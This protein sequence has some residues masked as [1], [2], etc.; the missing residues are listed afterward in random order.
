MSLEPLNVSTSI[1]ERF[2]RYLSTAFKVAPE[3]HGLNQEFKRLVREPGRLFR[4]PYLQGLPP[5][6]RQESLQELIDLG[7]LPESIKA[8]PFLGSPNQQLYAHQAESIKRVQ[9]GHN[10]VVTSGTGSGKTL[11]FMIP[12]IAEI[13][14]NPAPGIHTMLLYPMNALVQDQLKVLRT[15]LKGHPEVRFGRYVNVNVTP[16]SET[17]ARDLHPDSLPN[18][19]VSR[20]VFRKKPPHI[21]ITNFAMLEHLLMRASDS[22][23]FQG[24]WRFIAMDETHTYTGARGSEVALL[25]R[26]LMARVKTQDEPP[27]QFI[28]TS[29]TIGA[30][31]TKTVEEVAKFAQKLF[32]AP[33]GVE[34]IIRAEQISMPLGD[35]LDIDP[36]I[37]THAELED[38]LDHLNWSE[39][40]VPELIAAGFP[41]E[42]VDAGQKIAEKDFA[43]ALCHI[44]KHDRR[45]EALREAVAL[46]PDLPAGAH[47]VFGSRSDECIKSLIGLIRI[48]SLAKYSDTD[49]RLVPCRYHFFVRGLSG[50]FLAFDQ[51]GNDRKRQPSL[52]LEPTNT[53]PDGQY[54]TLELRLCRKCGQ[55][56]VFGY[57]FMEND[58]RVLKAF[59]SLREGRG[60]P[61]WFTWQPPKVVSE[62]EEDV[63]EGGDDITGTR[64]TY[65]SKCGVY[66]TGEIISCKCEKGDSHVPL[67]FLSEGETRNKCFACGGQNTLTGL[68]ADANAAQAVVAESFYRHLP[69][70]K[71]DTA[72]IYPGRGRKLLCFSDSR[73]QAAYFAPYLQHTH[74][75]QK[76]RWL[77]LN[78][79][80]QSGGKDRFVAAKNVVDFMVSINENERLFPFDMNPDDI[81]MDI[82]RALVLEFCMPFAR[83]QSL[84]ALA[85]VNMSV[86]LSPFF[87]F[88]DVLT[89]YGLNKEEQLDL[90]QTLLA[91]LR[92]N[93]MITMPQPLVPLDEAFAP[94]L[95]P[96]AAVAR[97][98]EDGYRWRLKGF[99][100]STRI[101]R[102][103]RGYYL[104]RV[105]KKAAER[106]GISPPSEEDVLQYLFDIWMAVTEVDGPAQI[107]PMERR[108]VS[109]GKAG[110]Q[111]RWNNLQITY[112]KTWYYC[113]SCNQWTPWN[114]AGI[115]PSFQCDG[116]LEKVDPEEIMG[117]NHYRSMYLLENPMPLVAKE[118]TAQLAPN[119]A[120]Q[121][122]VAFQKGH[123]KDAGQINILSCSTTFELGVDLGDLEAVFLRDA[124][125]SP[126]NYQQRAG[127]AGRG[128]GTAAF[129]VTFC[130]PRSHDEYYFSVPEEMISGIVAAPRIHL[131]NE[132]IV[133]RHIQAVLLSEFIRAQYPDIK[134]ISD[135]LEKRDRDEA[136]ID[137][138]FDQIE[139]LVEIHRRTLVTLIPDGFTDEYL[140]MVGNQAIVFFG[141]ARDHYFNE[142][143]MFEVAFEEAGRKHRKAM[144]DK[145]FD[146]KI[147]GF[148]SF[149]SKRMDSLKDVN[150]VVFFSD[151]GVLP[152]YAFPIYNVNLE[153]GDTGLNLDRDLRIAL[154]EYAPGAKVVANERL[155][156]S[157]GI[158]LPPRGALPAQYYA[159][160]P[161]CWY[162]ER[163]LDK[164]AIFKGGKCPV[165]DHD[166][167]SPLRRKQHYVVPEYGFT[168]DLEKGGE[169]ITFDRPERIPSSRV[170]F[171]P[172][173]DG[174]DPTIFTIGKEGRSVSLKTTDEAEF[175]V[176]NDGEDRSG[177][178]FFLCRSC[179]RKLDAASL[180][181][182]HNRPFGGECKGR[183]NWEHLGHEFRGSAARL[184][185]EG[186][187]FEYGEH[188][189]WQSLLYALLG[190][191]SEALSI[192][193]GDIDGIIRPVASQGSVV[194]EVVLFDNVPGGAGHVK[195]LESQE[196]LVATLEAAFRRVENCN[197]G[198]DASCYRCLR[199]Y[200][201]QYSHDLLM[202]GQ[203]AEYLGPLL[204]DTGVRRDEDI[205]YIH[206]DKS[207]ALKNLIERSSQLYVV[208]D[209][210]T[211]A[212]P[213]ETG[214]WHVLLQSAAARMG[215]NLKIAIKKTS[216]ETG[217][218][219]P[220][221]LL[222]QAGAQIH[223]IKQDAPVPTYSLLGV[224][225]E[226]RR[227]GYHFGEDKLVP[228]DSLTHRQDLWLNRSE[229]RLVSASADLEKWLGEETHLLGVFDFM[230]TGYKTHGFNDGDRFD[231]QH[232]FAS[233][234]S[235]GLTEIV[236]QDPYLRN[237]HQLACLKQ[238]LEAC[239]PLIQEE[240]IP[241]KIITKLSD[242]SKDRYAFMPAIHRQK[243]EELIKEFPLMELDLDMRGYR[244]R[245][246]ARFICFKGPGD[247]ETLF[248]L[249]RGLD[250]IDVKTGL[251]R[252]GPI[253]EFN[254]PDT[255]LKD[256]FLSELS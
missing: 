164:N 46:I 123:S 224:S 110:H 231:F 61:V 64:S 122:Q 143:K 218:A 7:V 3:Y 75:T 136:P 31:D 52:F 196:D 57:E 166:G 227:V 138:F 8:V 13:L 236:V 92:M 86:D 160:C 66:N 153:T 71:D 251:A 27:P 183:P 107:L 41:V 219:L 118:H 45:I 235:S 81:R 248:Y 104:N 245:V 171:V 89:Q 256:I 146:N 111:I 14:Q 73:Q 174:E 151:R 88:P 244:D 80:F 74:R 79:L 121:H 127:R 12:A 172:Q 11:C 15:L 186:T 21:L 94:L 32:N 203:V 72:L 63:V 98:S 76:L 230:K 43:E 87:K 140:N 112:P 206:T 210:L 33:F 19:V 115:C 226:G 232:V 233:N 54:K 176:F 134:K 252:G 187:G 142:L 211:T 69:E 28:A 40:L 155:W 44:F 20:E 240:K 99:V 105:L 51:I 114:A 85:L 135:F 185:F 6:R 177:R 113:H 170:L 9:D 198:R 102:Q 199:N 49:A 16:E 201:N 225:V 165:C 141:K 247:Q 4:G 84:E 154:S 55:P 221:L 129:V 18:E 200:R 25:M 182:P 117:Q 204:S 214:P 82:H 97:E 253:L 156:E 254:Q 91:S 207:S 65:C 159:R 124:P 50:G 241:L 35:D 193:L 205:R 246:H 139:E 181:K 62:D 149:L 228:L 101:S 191:M 70:S 215:G 58:Q 184:L 34:D 175:F 249:D 120:T 23:L 10:V 128:V 103:R 131:D 37:Y 53:T 39:T 189:F 213:A 100:P 60:K 217:M 229:K 24:P 157:V 163:H 77:I 36:I 243:L 168:T 173:Q 220:L 116:E 133:R 48:A 29:A 255:A 242:Q 47:H 194:Q 212:G 180:D 208:A 30:S 130:L 68:R 144:R 161:N 96:D 26:R 42:L 188:S 148:L 78:G 234:L 137:A 150:W 158:K 125:P 239:Q 209:E 145:K 119:L 38:C 178:G 5:Y 67:W 2:E 197:C 22:I 190:G 250:V 169:K 147:S 93:K 17:R 106:K 202:R 1:T 83:R 132:V 56:H 162:V 195:R 238:L 108:E 237:E 223:Q 95:G 126:T 59:G 222:H 90:V 216:S 192:E 109:R 167:K 152:R 179:G